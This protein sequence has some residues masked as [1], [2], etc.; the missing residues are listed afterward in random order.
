MANRSLDSELPST[1]SL[2]KLKEPSRK[3]LSSPREAPVFAWE[4]DSA[5]ARSLDA[6]W[7]TWN[8]QQQWNKVTRHWIYRHRSL[9]ILGWDLK[10]PDV[11]LEK[12]QDTRVFWFLGLTTGRETRLR[13]TSVESL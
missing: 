3:P 12:W 5:H 7:S 4:F 11:S 2:L 6:F 10:R 9:A 13:L 1:L 8:D